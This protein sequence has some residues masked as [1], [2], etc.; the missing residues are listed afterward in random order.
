MTPRTESY[1]SLATLASCAQKYAFA[2]VEGLEDPSLNLAQHNG[3][4]MHEAFRVLYRGGWDAAKLPEALRT[5][6]AAWGDVTPPFGD[7]KDF[8]TLAYAERRLRAYVDERERAPTVLETSEVIDA[9]TEEM[10]EFEWYAENGG[11]VRTRGIPDLVLR[12]AGGLLVVDNKFPTSTWISD[13]YWLRYSLGFQLRIY[14]AMV[15]QKSGEHVKGALINAVCCNEK[16]ADPPEAWTRRKSAPSAI[17]VISFT[18]SQLDDAHEW[19][20]G[21]LVVRDACAAAGTWPRNEMAC[22]D[23]GGCEFLP[24]CLAPSPAMRK[25]LMLTRFRRKENG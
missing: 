16:G 17:R 1:S 14:A 7:K 20:R 10:H 6:R 5:L 2:Y 22:D 21:N 12:D 18:R 3:S 19:I 13:Y 8:L 25:S 9:F 24:L 11:I 4:A 23:Y 15:E